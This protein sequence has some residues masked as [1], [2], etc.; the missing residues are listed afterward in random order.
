FLAA[1]AATASP[2]RA[3]P[4]FQNRH[5]THAEDGTWTDH[6]R[7]SSMAAAMAGADAMMADP[8]FG[9]FMAL[10]DGPTVTMRHDI[11]AFAMD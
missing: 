2:L 3:Q 11:I 1:A 7:W 6:V 10:I 9:P 8:A 4:G 5:L